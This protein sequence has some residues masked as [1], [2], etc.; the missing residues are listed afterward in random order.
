MG[1]FPWRVGSKMK[2]KRAMSHVLC[3]AFMGRKKEYIPET[4]IDKNVIIF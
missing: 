4:N 1:S 2:E 3:I